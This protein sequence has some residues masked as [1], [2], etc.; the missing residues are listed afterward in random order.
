MVL[1][2]FLACCLIGAAANL[3]TAAELVLTE[4]DVTEEALVQ[5]LAKP[6][7][8]PEGEPVV[9]AR[10]I[11]M[12]ERPPEGGRAGLLITFLM[13]SA[14]LSGSARTA[15]GTAARAMR[16]Q[17][18]GNLAFTIEGHADPRGSS[19]HNQRL[20][21]ARA[22]SVVRHLSD[23][24]GIP[25]ERLTPIGLGSTRP[26]NREDPGAPENRRVSIVSR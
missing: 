9:R 1:R 7:A 10:G 15:L 22:E 21:Q 23:V 18:L 20:S 17:R 19:E 5:A 2:S 26:L 11:R 6:D 13:D 3:A 25:R 24:E 8:E 14:Q 16:S 4:Q 12:M